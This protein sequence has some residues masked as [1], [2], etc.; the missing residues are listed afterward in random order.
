MCRQRMIS[1]LSAGIILLSTVSIGASKSAATSG[2][3][4]DVP[5]VRQQGKN[6]CGAASL[7]MLMSYWDRQEGMTIST[8][9]RQS[10]IEQALDPRNQG[11]INSAMISYLRDSGFR[12][13]A[14]SGQW[15]DL[16]ENLSR[17]RP[18]IVGLG[19]DAS[20]G[21]FHY[22]VVTGI[23]WERNLVFVNDP[24]QRK[25]F[26]MTG[27]QFAAEWRATGPLWTG[28]RH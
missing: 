5:F 20:K 10:V 7:S 14:F 28:R 13:F 22:V 2:V 16:R 27:E 9:A 6:T 15:E 26:R 18:L 3:M 4:L 23:D 12:V 24:A 11:V 25:L 8:S 21:P 1:L 17:G 19:P